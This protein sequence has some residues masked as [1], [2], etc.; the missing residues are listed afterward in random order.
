MPKAQP[1][2]TLAELQR[3][4]LSETLPAD[5]RRP[6][7]CNACNAFGFEL[8]RWQEHD[9]HDKPLAIIVALC[10]GCS[11]QLIGAH[12]RLYRKL[13]PNDPWPGC[14]PLC[15]ECRHRR[16]T[17]CSHPAAKANGGDG[18]MLTVSR[19][20]YMHLNYGGGRGESRWLYPAPPSACAQREVEA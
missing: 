8:T 4:G 3:P 19:P 20:S 13:W 17:S 2:P 15:V 14:M 10:D 7:R 1:Q 12:A 6:D 5:Y 11:K 18:V 16:G 9:P